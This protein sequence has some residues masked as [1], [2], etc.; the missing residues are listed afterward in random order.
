MVTPPKSKMAMKATLLR[1]KTSPIP[2]KICSTFTHPKWPYAGS[3]FDLVIILCT[4]GKLLL[5]YVLFFLRKFIE[6]ILL[7]VQTYLYVV[8]GIIKEVYNFQIK[9][10]GYLLKFNT[11]KAKLICPSP[12]EYQ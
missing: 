2:T 5:Q 4:T 3:I 1:R 10:N 12:D 7:Q 9:L 8:E 11:C 6:K